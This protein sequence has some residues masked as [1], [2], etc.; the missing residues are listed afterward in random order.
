MG[1]IQSGKSGDIVNL[2]KVEILLSSRY[3]L[4]FDIKLL[5]GKILQRLGLNVGF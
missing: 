5:Y 2:Y 4:S 3:L 1:S